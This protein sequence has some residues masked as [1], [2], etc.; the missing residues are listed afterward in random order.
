MKILFLSR[1]FPYPADNGSKLR[2]LNLLRGLKQNHD[3]TLLSFSDQ[4]Q[5]KADVP[6]DIRSLCSE[7]YTIPWREYDPHSRRAKLGLLSLKPRSLVDTFSLEMAGTEKPNSSPVL[8]VIPLHFLSATRSWV[9]F[10]VAR[11][12][13]ALT[14][15][16]SRHLPA[17]H[18]S[19][20][21][22][23]GAKVFVP[24]GPQANRI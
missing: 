22:G 17:M 2:I 19:R 21:R 10:R 5:E 9:N 13:R 14:K 12:R 23:L 24:S 6:L 11:H 15:Y 7:I 16:R 4:P 1:W 18:S 8:L 20:K 3:V